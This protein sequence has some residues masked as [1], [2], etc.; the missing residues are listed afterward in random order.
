MCLENNIMDI[1]CH[2]NESELGLDLQ[3]RNKEVKI[4]VFDR[5]TCTPLV[6]SGCRESTSTVSGVFDFFSFVLFYPCTKITSTLIAS[7]SEILRRI[8]TQMS[9][10]LGKSGW[11][12]H[13]S[14]KILITLFRTLT[15]ES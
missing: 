9:V 11:R 5:N 4:V 13:T 3:N 12:T 15:P 14:F 6:G 1:N 10:I 8:L 2:I 7:S